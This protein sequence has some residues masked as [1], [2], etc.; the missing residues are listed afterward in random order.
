MLCKESRFKTTSVGNDLEFVKYIWRKYLK[1]LVIVIFEW[2]DFRW[3]K[4]P[5][6]VSVFYKFSESNTQ[7]RMK[8]LKVKI[9]TRLLHWQASP[10]LPKSISYFLPDHQLA[11]VLG[12]LVLGSHDTLNTASSVLLHVMGTQLLTDTY[13]YFSHLLTLS[14]WGLWKHGAPPLLYPLISFL[15]VWWKV[16]SCS[17]S[18]FPM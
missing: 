3:F 12:E 14:S 18:V 4:F 2:W 7:K 15:W 8:L 6:L 13:R 17:L 9:K 11:E 10:T 1:I 16:L 5:S